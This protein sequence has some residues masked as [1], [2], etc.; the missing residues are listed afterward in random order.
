MTAHWFEI[1]TA[2]FY[3]KGERESWFCAPQSCKEENSEAFAGQHAEHHGLV[4]LVL[5]AV[6]A[7]EAGLLVGVVDVVVC[8]RGQPA[9]G[10]ARS[11][12]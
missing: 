2:R 1:N 12:P 4:D 5:G 6:V 8:E 10:C 9:A 3:R 11:D 7:A